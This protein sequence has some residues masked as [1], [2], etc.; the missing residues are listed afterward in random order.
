MSVKM[1]LEV[2]VGRRAEADIT[3]AADGLAGCYALANG[4]EVGLVGDVDILGEGAVVEGEDE[5]VPF[6]E[7]TDMDGRELA[8]RLDNINDA[9]SNGEDGRAARAGKVDG[10]V[11]CG[12]DEVGEKAAG[13]LGAQERAGAGEGKGIARGGRRRGGPRR[14][15]DVYYVRGNGLGP[16]NKMKARKDIAHPMA[17]S[18]TQASTLV[19]GPT[20]SA[21]V[22]IP[23]SP[24]ARRPARPRRPTPLSETWYAARLARHVFMHVAH[25]A[26]LAP[27]AWR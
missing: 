15:D 3:R 19:R 7:A 16:D 9:V 18:R 11:N 14:L 27:W 5:A 10:M 2:E 8:A 21:R 23:A 1:H 12:V 24:G 20:A 25:V 13:G 4:D 6:E 17:P 22:A 26:H